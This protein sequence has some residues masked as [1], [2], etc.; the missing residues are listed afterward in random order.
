MPNLTRPDQSHTMQ[1]HNKKC[2]L[3]K[4]CKQF[5]QSGI[6]R[7]LIDL[8]EGRES[9]RKSLEVYGSGY[10]LR[11]LHKRRSPLKATI[12]RRLKRL[13]CADKK[14]GWALRAVN[15]AFTVERL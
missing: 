8:S 9:E 12:Q 4:S 11:L 7:N 2:W 10:S 14:F 1:G 15:L 13:N 3:E 5:V 6:P